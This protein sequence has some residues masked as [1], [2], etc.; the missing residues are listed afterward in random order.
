[1]PLEYVFRTQRKGKANI[2]LGWATAC[3]GAQVEHE[4]KCKSRSEHSWKLD[5]P[6]AS[7]CDKNHTPTL[8][9]P[10]LF[11]R[12]GTRLKRKYAIVVAQIPERIQNRKKRGQNIDSKESNDP[13]RFPAATIVAVLASCGSQEWR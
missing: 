6:K 9:L 12:I 7:H 8:F 10:L 13:W 1:M 3:A 2:R 5:G 11:H 4:A